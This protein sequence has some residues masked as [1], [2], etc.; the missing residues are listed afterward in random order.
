MLGHD[1]MSGWGSRRS[2]VQRTQAPLD[3]EAGGELPE[4]RTGGVRV[5]RQD[6]A[7][8]GGAGQC[9]PRHHAGHREPSLIRSIGGD[10]VASKDHSSPRGANGYYVYRA[11]WSP[12]SQYLSPWQFPTMVYGRKQDR[13]VGLSDMI[14]GNPTVSGEFKFTGP[15][16]P[17]HHVEATGLAG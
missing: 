13:I 1:A 7:R 4:Y 8:R 10:T 12:D 17:R 6:Y 5:T 14:N 16:P 9:Q 11:K 2:A 15:H 3:A